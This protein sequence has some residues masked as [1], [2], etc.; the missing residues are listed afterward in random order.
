MKVLIYPGDSLKIEVGDSDGVFFIQYDVERSGQLT[1]TADM[2]DTT[3]R[4][5]TIYCEDFNE[6]KPFD[7]V[8]APVA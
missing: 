3:G 2:P 7:E 4:E 6:L 8:S 1:I 5:G